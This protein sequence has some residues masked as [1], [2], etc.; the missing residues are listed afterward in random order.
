MEDLMMMH[1][2]NVEDLKERFDSR[3]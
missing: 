1:G 3:D 2:K